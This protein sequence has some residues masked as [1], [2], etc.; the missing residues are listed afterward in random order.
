MALVVYFAA[1]GL[2]KADKLGSVIGVLIAVVGLALAAYGLLTPQP[3]DSAAAG[4]RVRQEA[5]AT[6]EGEIMQIGGS[7]GRP[8]GR[9]RGRAG[10]EVEQRAR[11]RKSK[12]TQ[13]GGDQEG[14]G[15]EPRETP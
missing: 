8:S 2:D 6:K 9:R 7:Q 1:V 11:A 15:R 5:E 14:E 12:V 13:I 10:G 3:P 4:R